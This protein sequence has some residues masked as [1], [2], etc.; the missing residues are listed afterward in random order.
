MKKDS[1]V[2]RMACRVLSIAADLPF[3]WGIRRRFDGR[4]RARENV[5]DE[6]VEDRLIL[7]GH[8]LAARALALV[9]VLHSGQVEKPLEGAVIA[10]EGFLALP[11]DQRFLRRNP[12]SPA[13]VVQ[14]DGDFQGAFE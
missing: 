4:G 6:G 7:G 5:L 14:G 12:F 13:L 9:V 8:M 11:Q 10:L 2:R 3:F 1:S